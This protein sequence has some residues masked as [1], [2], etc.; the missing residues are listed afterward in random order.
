M[1]EKPQFVL[2]VEKHL[3]LQCVPDAMPRYWIVESP[4][5]VPMFKIGS[6]SDGVIGSV[7]APDMYEIQGITAAERYQRRKASGAIR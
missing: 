5:G 3:G 2:D 1:R 7:S 6:H 4:T